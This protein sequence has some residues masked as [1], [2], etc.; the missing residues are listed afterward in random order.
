VSG[1]EVRPWHY[2]R[3]MLDALVVDRERFGRTQNLVVAPTGTGKTVVAALDYRALREGDGGLDVGDDPTLLFVAH[4]EQLLDQ[5]LATFRHVLARGDFGE[6]LVGGMR[7]R[8]WRHVFASVQSLHAMGVEQLDP[9]QF[10]VVYIDEFHHAEATTYRAL[11]DHL[12]PKVTVGLTATPERA[13]GVN[14]R[15]LFHGHYTFEMRLWDALDQQLLAPFHYYGIADNTDLS[16]LT[17]QR[18]GYRISDLEQLYVIDGHDARTAKVLRALRDLAGDTSTMRAFG[19]C[20]SVEHARYMARKFTQAGIPAEAMT[21]DTAPDVRR[22]QLDRLKAKELN[23]LFAVDVLTEGVDVP[24]VD[25]ILLLRP[26]ESATV[27]LQQIGRGLR[28]HRDKSVCTVMD[29]VGQQ[30]RRFRSDLRLRALTGRSRGQL[31]SDVEAGFP[32]LPAGC[33]MRLDRESEQAILDNLKAVTSTSADAL[34]AELASLQDQHGRLTLAEFLDHAAID[35]DDIY[36]RTTW[37]DLQRRAGATVPGPGPR[38]PELRRAFAGSSR[39][40]TANGLT[41]SARWEPARPSRATPGRSGLP[42]CWGSCC[43][44]TAPRRRPSMGWSGHWPTNPRP[45]GSWA[46]SPRYWTPRPTT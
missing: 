39:W 43:S 11:L 33:H 13:D 45:D 27:F 38:E 29:F 5:S 21:G 22:S 6:K 15:D 24:S 2:Q 17:W 31:I 34:A 23:V 25:T 3:E 44:T 7:P 4:R 40:M 35:L 9:Q 41:C 42:R 12:Q 26:T 32:Y 14:V 10:D 20:V 18:G 37:T 8:A 16:Q 36:R 1:L 30:H 19:F 28:L 46:S